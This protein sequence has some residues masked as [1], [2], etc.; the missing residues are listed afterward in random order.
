MKPISGVNVNDSIANPN[1]FR[2]RHCR[3]ELPS[4]STRRRAFCNRA[5]RLRAFR[6]RKAG[7]PEQEYRQGASRGRVRLGELTKRE[8]RAAYFRLITAA[9][10]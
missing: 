10:R 7:L 3:A 4:T 9:R 5:C 2:C 1:C 8:S 6:R